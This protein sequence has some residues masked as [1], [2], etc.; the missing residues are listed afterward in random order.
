MAACRSRSRR[1]GQRTSR[2]A[3]G[4]LD[5]VNSLPADALGEL[6]T[7]KAE[8]RGHRPTSSRCASRSPTSS[9][10]P[11][12]PSPLPRRPARGR[13]G[14]GAARRPAAPTR[15]PQAAHIE[16]KKAAER[17][18]ARQMEAEAGQLAGRPRGPSGAG[19]GSPRRLPQHAGRPPAGP[20]AVPGGGFLRGRSTRRSPRSS[21]TRFHPILHY[22]RL[23]AG[24]DFAAVR[25]PGAR[26]RRRHVI[27]A[28]WGGGYGNRIV[29]DH[30]LR[31]RRRPGDD[32]QPPDDHPAQRR[33]RSPRP[34]DRLLRHHRH[35]TGCHLHFETLENG[36]R[37][38]RAAGSE[39]RTAPR[40]NAVAEPRVARSGSGSHARRAVRRSARALSGKGWRRWPR[41]GAQAD[42]EQPQGAARLPHRGRLRGR[43][44]AHRHRGEVAAAGPRVARR[45]VRDSRARRGCG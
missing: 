32:V 25:H 44:G 3:S 20:G 5:Q 6:A 36:S 23:H 45:R 19:R 7:T 27:S 39:R 35:S 2:P 31:Q 40:A 8:G 18:P 16:A 12:E 41:S 33:A 22:W 10:R 24:M 30:G 43:P 15:P 13:H 42:R 1:S 14:E 29:I 26:G 37:S 9:T 17:R 34:A 38:T 4:P 28:G 21:A 11:S